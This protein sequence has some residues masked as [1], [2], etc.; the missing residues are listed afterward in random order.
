MH[1][2]IVKFHISQNTHSYSAGYS[3]KTIHGIVNSAQFVNVSFNPPDSPFPVILP[4]IGHLGSFDRPSADVGD[5]LDLYVHGYVSSRIMNLSRQGSDG[6]VVGMPVCVSATHVDG[7]VLTL[8]A[9]NHNYNYRSAILFGN[10]TLVQSEE[11]KLYAME[12]ITNSVVPQ[13]FRNARLPITKAELQST[14]LLKIKIVSASSKIHRGNATDTKQDEENADAV[15]SIWTGVLPVHTTIGD[16]IPGPKN[17]VKELPEY[18]K[19]FRDDF[20]KD[21]K[22]YSLDAVNE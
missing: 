1:M 3:L 17:Q 7:L 11:E 4:M 13:R 10:A 6:E 22:E 21:N 5:P 14:A 2:H 12:L 20:N 9:F 18:I 19:E 16:P 15:N 8:A